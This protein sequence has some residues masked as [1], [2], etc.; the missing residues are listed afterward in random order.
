MVMGLSHGLL[1]VLGVASAGC[2]A[3]RRLPDQL[4]ATQL[5]IRA[6]QTRTYAGQDARTVLKTLLSVLQD[7]GF[8]VHYGDVELGLLD[9]SKSVTGVDAG[10][11]GLAFPTRV[12]GEIVGTTLG[13]AT[14]E[15]TAN[16]SEFGDRV[17]VRVNF[18]R[19]L[20]DS[21]GNVVV[22]TVTDAKGYQEFFAKLDKGLFLQREGL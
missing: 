16:V 8:L 1:V 12:A 17:K 7:D 5:E 11:F 10:D 15:A 21:S 20:V 9:A 19:R 14:V 18:Q 6:I 22:T 13:V 2:F 4:P 3:A